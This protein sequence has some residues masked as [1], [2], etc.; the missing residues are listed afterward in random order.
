MWPF[1]GQANLYIIVPHSGMNLLNQIFSN[2]AGMGNVLNNGRLRRRG[3][4]MVVLMMV[5]MAGFGQVTNHYL[6]NKEY[7]DPITPS[8]SAIRKNHV[9]SYYYVT[10]FGKGKK[11]NPINN[12]EKCQL[13]FDKSGNMIYGFHYSAKDTNNI[14]KTDQIVYTKN[15]KITSH[16]LVDTTSKDNGFKMQIIYY[17][18]IHKDSLKFDSASFWGTEKMRIRHQPFTMAKHYYHYDKKNNLISDSTYIHD[19]RSDDDGVYKLAII[20]EYLYDS[21]NRIIKENHSGFYPK[22]QIYNSIE[23]KYFDKLITIIESDPPYRRNE[24]SHDPKTTYLS[25][26]TKSNL[27]N[28]EIIYE[29]CSEWSLFYD[30]KNVI[31]KEETSEQKTEYFYKNDL[32]IKVA[33]SMSDLNGDVTTYRYEFY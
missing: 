26:D 2:L 3:W 30:Y 13:N 19:P 15:K 7:N 25:F 22:R 29:N 17:D 1:N 11:K 28:V 18:I 12:I 6:I 4:M 5:G 16:Q 9:K 8:L 20:I 10:V 33:Q 14:E 27:I 21:L 31:R 32:L 24:N 23:Y